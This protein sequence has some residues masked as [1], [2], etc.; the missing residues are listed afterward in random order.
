MLS[1]APLFSQRVEGMVRGAEAGRSVALPGAHVLW[2]GTEIGATSGT[3]G[4]VSIDAPVSWPASLVVRYVGYTTDTVRLD[5]YPGRPIE[6]MLD[7]A[8]ELRAIEIVER[9]ESTRMDSRSLLSSEQLGVKELKRAA[10]CDLSESFETNATVDIS[11]S[12]AISGTKAIRM[13][14]LDGKYAQLS[15]EN[16]PF[17]RGLSSVYGLTLLPGTWINA[18]NVSKGVGTAVNGPNAM[19]GQIDLCLVS[20]TPEEPLFVNLYGNSQ[21]RAEA[22][23]HVSHRAGKN[24]S[25]LLLLHGN[26]FGNEMDQNSDGFM[27]MPMGRRINVMDRWIYQ[28][29][30]RA[31][32]VGVRFVVDERN[33]GQSAKH[34]GDAH[35]GQAHDL[36]RVNITNRMADVIAKNGYIFKNDATKSIGVTMALKHHEVTSTFGER[37]YC[38]TQQSAYASAIYQMLLGTG[39]DQLKAGASFQYDDYI[40]AFNDS[41]FARNEVMPGLFTEYTL[42]RGSV[43]W[44][45]GLRGDHNSWFGT[46][47]SP[48][49]HLKIDLGPLTNLR[50]SAGYGFRTANPLVENASVLASSRRVIMEGELGMERA[51]NFGLGFLHKFKWLDRKWAIGADAFRTQFTAQVIADLDRSP[52]TLV[53]YMLDGPSYANSVLADVQVGLLRSLDLKLSYRFYDVVSTY[54]GVLRE[55]PFTPRHRGLIDLAWTS[56]DERWRFDVSLNLFGDARIPWTT[57]NPEEFRFPRRSPAYCTLHAQI[58]RVFGAWEVYLGG[59]NLT[60]TLQQRQIIAPEDPFGP[61]F[62]ASLIWGPTN[63]AMIYG[64]LRFL[65]TKR[66][67]TEQE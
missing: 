43:T 8:V 7:Q 9:Q 15:V 65:L 59:E 63:R 67:K 42:K 50:A 30:D 49:T 61:Y 6:V 11:F 20:P 40:E 14:G 34:L 1:A 58:S 53:F 57:Q 54:D 22:N 46:A 44:V 48:R 4:R 28:R 3:D 21:G 62:D 17:I 45:A 26:Y 56:N 13:L 19:T 18:I 16:L 36:Y 55:R 32:Q 64:G 52:R 37:D 31:A 29:G 35:A 27:D 60:S 10:C 33:G 2:S 24:G 25:N 23:V 12:D 47:V 38:G 41:S 51:W 39:T 66:T 5:R